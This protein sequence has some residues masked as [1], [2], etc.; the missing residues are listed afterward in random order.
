MKEITITFTV[1][2][3]VDAELLAH[4]IALGLEGIVD[5][6]VILR[7][8]DFSRHLIPDERTRR[9]WAQ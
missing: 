6:T 2:D 7:R 5:E 1:E 3:T 9:R 8:H 4:D